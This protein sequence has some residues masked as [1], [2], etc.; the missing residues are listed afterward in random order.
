MNFYFDYVYY[1][2]C[3]LYYKYDKGQG[4]YGTTIITMTEG[5][6]LVETVIFFEK[7]FFTTQQLHSSKLIGPVIVAICILPFGVINYLNYVLPKG[8]YEKFDHYWKN[9]TAGKRIFKGFLV[10]ISI[11]IPW[12]LMFPLNT[13]YQCSHC[14]FKN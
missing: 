1:R 8:N 2:I 9:E 3:K 6:L 14:G 13:W 10:L 5:V 4:V 11:L 7:F 12:I